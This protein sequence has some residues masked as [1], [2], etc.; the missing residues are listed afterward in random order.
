M[1][2]DV[3]MR[4][5]N[6]T[7][8]ERETSGGL[9]SKDRAGELRERWI[10]VQSRFVDDPRGAVKDADAL[11]ADV[12]DDLSTLFKEERARLDEELGSGDRMDT[13]DLRVAIRRYRS[14][15]DRLLSL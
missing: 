11:V 13:E 2:E 10:E 8:E 1:S 12:I 15:F 6:G 9:F 4:D 7:V 5:G 3:E 14:F